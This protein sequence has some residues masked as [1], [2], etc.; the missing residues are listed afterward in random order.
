MTTSKSDPKILRAQASRAARI[1]KAVGRGEKVP[2]DV[3][4]RLAASLALGSVKF[5]IVMVMILSS[6]TMSWQLIQ[7]CDELALIDLIL[8]EMASKTQH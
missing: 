3:N 4:G 8:R 2:E 7:D 5:C 6:I 1:L